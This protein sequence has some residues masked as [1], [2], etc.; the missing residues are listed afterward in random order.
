MSLGSRPTANVVLT[1]ASSDEAKATVSGALTFTPL[2]WMREQAVTVTGVP[3]GEGAATI[4]HTISSADA[5]YGSL[6]VCPGTV[7]VAEG[8]TAVYRGS[9]GSRPTANV[10]LTPASSDEA[11]ATVAGATADEGADAEV[12]VTLGEGAPTGGLSLNVVYNYSISTATAADVGTVPVSVTV[13]DGARTATLSIPITDD[14]V[15]EG[16]ESFRVELSASG[17]TAFSSGANRAVVTITDDEASEA[18]IAFGNSTATVLSSPNYSTFENIGGA[19]Y[20]IPVTIN[21][22]PQTNTTFT[23]QVLA[24]STATE[25][26]DYSIFSKTFTFGPTDTSMTKNVVV[27]IED[28][29]ASEANET[30]VLRIAAADTPANDPGGYFERD[31]LSST[32]TLV[33]VDNDTATSA[34]LTVDAVDGTAV[35]G[36]SAVRVTATLDGPAPSGGARINLTTSGTA[37]ASDFR[38]SSDTLRVAAGAMTASVTLTVVDDEFAESDET[39][40]LGGLAR[41]TS[42]VLSL[43][44]VTLTIGDNDTVGVAVTPTSLAMPVGQSLAYTVRLLSPPTADVT[45]AVASGAAAATVSPASLVFS[46]SNWSDEQTVTV[47][48][49]S[50]GS[51][52]VSHTV[53]SSDEAYNGFSVDSVAV[54]VN[55]LAKTIALEA[56]TA[57]EGANA[58]INVTLGE[59]APSGGLALTVAYSYGGGASADDHTVVASYLVTQGE[60]RDSSFLVP[61]TDDSLVENQESFTVTAS[62]SGWSDGTATVTVEDIHRPAAAVAFGLLAT[63]AQVYEMEVAEDVDGQ[64]LSVPVTVSDRP[65]VEVTFNV[66]IT[67]GSATDNGDYRIDDL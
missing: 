31:A 37:S 59:P 22:L 3:Q 14:D 12:V 64:Q 58:V 8:G 42:G 18:K 7:G 49:A 16:P 5:G 25:G 54:T 56:V 35:E 26:T 51:A 43:V 40:V 28:D 34:T 33:I 62:A 38:F 27:S 63:S 50:A 45:I 55:A 66:E 6:S 11:T 19:G 48:G 67:G 57:K 30:V 60:W 4:T 36:G 10:V 52:T 13:P 46:A 32:A 53:T 9:I 20:E 29:A 2:N 15:V 47:N 39:V 41:T 44:G 21:R 61:I 1:P 23:V 65:D 24:A 17:W